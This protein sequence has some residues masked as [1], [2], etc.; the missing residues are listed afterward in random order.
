MAALSNLK[1]PAKFY[2]CGI[3]TNDFPTLNACVAHIKTHVTEPDFSNKTAASATNTVQLQL[4]ASEPGSVG[5]KYFNNTAVPTTEPNI[6]SKLASSLQSFNT[7]TRAVTTSVPISSC[8]QK[9]ILVQTD[10]CGTVSVRA[11][12]RACAA[13]GPGRKAT[14]AETCTEKGPAMGATS[15]EPC[16]SEAQQGPGRKATDVELKACT[17]QGPA[18]KA[19][20]VESS[21]CTEQG[22]ARKATDV[23]RKACTEQGPIRKATDVESGVC[24]GQGPVSKTTDAELC[25]RQGQVRKSTDTSVQ[26]T[27]LQDTAG[28]TCGQDPQEGDVGEDPEAIEKDSFHGHEDSNE[29]AADTSHNVNG[30][31]E[32]KGFMDKAAE[33]SHNVN[34]GREAGGIQKPEEAVSLRPKASSDEDR[35]YACP[36]C[37][38]RY[39]FLSSLSV[40]KKRHFGSQPY[41]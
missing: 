29:N 6:R 27:Q 5:R 40:H 8:K 4:Q 34:I 13:Q 36:E 37:P 11:D 19:A 28:S 38:C 2:R 20:D 12:S 10:I 26:P 14:D 24:L 33:T 35:P 39:R 9:S 18:R 31:K 7:T 30:D 16:A 21:G 25:T 1:S 32:A 17:E 15:I 3:C 23:E 22:P 41:Q